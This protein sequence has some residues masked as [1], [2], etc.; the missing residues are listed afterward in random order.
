MDIPK[1]FD[2]LSC[3]EHKR[4]FFNAADE[5]KILAEKIKRLEAEL[6]RIKKSQL[7]Q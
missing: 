2:V 3:I 1:N 4:L 6:A 7:D 5:I